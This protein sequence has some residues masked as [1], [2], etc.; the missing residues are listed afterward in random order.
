MKPFANFTYPLTLSS[1]D[2]TIAPCPNKF[3]IVT[4][5]L[6]GPSFQLSLPM[7]ALSWSVIGACA[8]VSRLCASN[9]PL[10][11]YAASIFLTVTFVEL[12]IT[13]SKENTLEL[14]G[15]SLDGI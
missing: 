9:A 1:L 8:L 14:I 15:V 2:A 4:S 7:I 11:R 6:A 10:V 13:T 3:L 12:P 5:V